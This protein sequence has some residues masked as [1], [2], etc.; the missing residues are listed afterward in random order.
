M[1]AQEISKYL[2]DIAPKSLAY[3]GEEFDFI[4]GDESKDIKKIGVTWR[5]TVDVLKQ[6]S[7]NKIDLLIT[8]EPLFHSE[9]SAIIPKKELT[10]S[11]NKERKRLLS[12]NNILVYRYHSQ[13]DDAKDGNNETLVKLFNLNN[14]IRIPFGRIGE[15]TPLTLIKFVQ[16]VK[17]KLN[18]PNILLTSD[19]DTKI[20]NKIAVISGSGNSLVEMIEYVKQK[21]ADV[22]VSGDIAD[23]RARYA[24]EINLP[25]I[26][27]GGYFSEKPGMKNLYW[28]LKKK[29]PE[30]EVIFIDTKKP[31]RVL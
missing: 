28:I 4:F 20:I 3:E 25:L 11:P 6:A 13:W 9:K 29:F 2:E 7:E 30:L 24:T 22:L 23:G 31:W 15:I 12:K 8:H 19:E 1:K 26:D 27:V 18:C 17:K 21:G 16:V 14:T 10:F 5:P